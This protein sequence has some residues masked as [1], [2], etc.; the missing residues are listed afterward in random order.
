MS[1]EFR[2]EFMKQRITV[3]S[4]IYEKHFFVI[5]AHFLHEKAKIFV[6]TL[7]PLKIKIVFPATTEKLKIEKLS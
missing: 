7:E 4:D 2:G 3:F 6:K 1:F 5:L